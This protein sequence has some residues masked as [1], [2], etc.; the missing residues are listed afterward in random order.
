M[1]F[2]RPGGQLQFSRRREVN[3]AGRST[4]Q[5][6]QRW[7][8]GNLTADTGLAALAARAGLSPR[9]LARLF[10]QEIGMTPSAWM[11]TVRIDAARRLLESGDRPKQVAAACGFNDIDTFRRAFVRRV[12]VTPA[13]YRRHHEPA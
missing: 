9:H 12:G 2:K 8:A 11:E 3:P 10:R 1:F 4:L 5:A 7:A 6:L 13:G